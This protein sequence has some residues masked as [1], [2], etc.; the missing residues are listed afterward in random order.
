MDENTP[1]GPRRKTYEAPPEEAVFTGSLPVLDEAPDEQTSSPYG[2]IPAPPVRTSLPE[3]V[4][5]E[6]F[7]EPSAGS[8]SELMAELERQVGLK[9]SEERAFEVWAD[10]VRSLRGETAEALIARE[11]IIFDGGDPGPLVEDVVDEAETLEDPEVSDTAAD[12]HGEVEEH[13]EDASEPSPL[14]EDEIQTPDSPA[15]EV[16]SAVPTETPAPSQTASGAA[17]SLPWA[18]ASWW[19]LGIPVAAVVTGAYLSFRGLGILES[20]VVLG[21]VA[22]L[23]GP[24][25]GVLSHQGFRRGLSSQDLLRGSFGHRASLPISLVIAVVQVF[26]AVVLLSWASELI[27]GILSASGLWPYDLGLG[28][29]GAWV[30]VVLLSAVITLVGRRVHRGALVAGSVSALLAL[31]LLIVIAL[32]TFEVSPSWS[33]DAGWMSVMSAGSLVLA[34]ASIIAFSSGDLA[35]LEGTS[36]TRSGGALSALA[37]VVPFLAMATIASWMAQSSQ[38]LSLGLRANP[39]GVLTE[40]APAWYPGVAVIAA[41]IPLVVFASVLARSASLV[42]PII[43]MPGHWRVHTAIVVGLLAVSGSLVIAFGVDLM[44]VAAD[45]AITIGVVIGAVAV[46][47]AKEWAVMGAQKPC[48]APRVR[49]LPLVALVVAIAVGWG[50]VESDVSWLAWHGYLFPILEQAGLI[51]ISAAQPGVL[52]S[53]ALAGIIAGFGALGEWLRARRNADANAV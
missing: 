46:V 24:I 37:L 4:I 5:L 21:L 19:G 13:A 51:D 8:T 6:Q 14:P 28:L 1:D 20:V 2:G 38:V 34:V 53:F 26:G 9:E 42:A 43:P 44:D 29:W 11:R 17:L 52:V 27:V 30:F 12:E 49:W 41:V 50:L 10:E 25:V 48:E 45:L 31:A 23:I 15:H 3:S 33:W 47:L 22:L 36:T 32:P 40:G 7:R 35:T 39:V 16:E 18:I